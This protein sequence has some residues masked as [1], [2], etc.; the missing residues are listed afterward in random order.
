[1][2]GQLTAGERAIASSA[3]APFTNGAK[4]PDVEVRWQGPPLIPF[5]VATTGLHSFTFQ[6]NLSTVCG[7]GGAFMGGFG[8]V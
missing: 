7:I 3:G 5:Q 1:M 6:L 2:R 8:G 4:G